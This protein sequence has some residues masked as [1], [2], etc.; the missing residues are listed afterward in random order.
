[1]TVVGL[2]G[3]AVA[4]DIA[5]VSFHAADNMPSAAAGTAG[6]TSAVDIGYTD[7]LK[8]AGHNVTRI[9]TS[10]APNVS[11]LNT[12][13]LVII[14]RGNP[15]G[16]FQTAASSAA[17]ASVL[18][19]T[20][21]LGGYAIRGGTDGNARLGFTTGSTIPDITGPVN[22]TIDQPSHAIFTGIPRTGNVMTNPFADLVQAPVPNAPATERGISVNTNPLPAGGVLL[23]SL[24]NLTAGSPGMVIGEFP[25]GTKLSNAT[26]DSQLG[27]RLVFLTGSRES[28]TAPTN[29]AEAAGILDLSAN[30]RQMFLNAVNYMA[31][32]GID[33]PGDVNDN[34]TVDINDYIVIRNNFNQ[35]NKTRATG[36]VNFDGAVN[37]A[38]FRIWKNNRTDGGVGTS[39]G[40]DSLPTVPE[41]GSLAL[42]A[43]AAIS[44]VAAA[45]RRGMR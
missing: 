6:F 25:T 13:D 18:T 5:W 40:I 1:M 24:P 38:D 30:G 17:W 32:I 19:P 16:N 2:A 21:H 26:M 41:P 8:G 3:R 35:T 22:L 44:W 31:N 7:L 37:F 10:A 29:T 28:G 39:L 33:I 34:G 15:S 43:L 12:F 4:A 11:Q 27:P 36:D 14:S 45:G 20:I 9:L 42:A 23:A